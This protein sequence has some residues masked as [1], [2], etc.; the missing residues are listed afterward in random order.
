MKKFIINFI[1]LV[2]F[3]SQS[4]AAEIIDVKGL[5]FWTDT[6]GDRANPAIL[7]IMGGGGQGIMWN[8]R[9]CNGLA[10]KGYFVIRFD[11]RDTGESS[12]IDYAKNP[13]SLRE[14]A[15]DCV[16]IL[17]HYNK[18]DGHIVGVSMGGA[19]A[20]IM[21]HQFPQHIKTLTLISTSYD[22]RT[23]DDALAGRDIPTEGRLSPPTQDYVKAVTSVIDRSNEDVDHLVDAWQLVNGSK[24][25]F[26]R[27]ETR[28]LVILSESRKGNPEATMNQ[29][30]AIAA[31]N[32]AGHLDQPE[33]I[34]VPTLVIHGTEDPIFP[35]D[36]GKA[37][38]QKIQ[39]SKLHVMNLMGHTFGRS[40]E[41]RIVAAITDFIDRVAAE[42]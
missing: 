41:P 15:E 36:H 13:Y 30:K 22:F 5:K 19:I 35:L 2:A 20:Q 23:F 33:D 4:I 37:L 7:L 27:E 8:E 39:G 17:A 9:F 6:F 24:V 42:G 10:E 26:D 18:Y 31:S 3:A 29:M 12:A 14:L 11:N 25:A 28:Q 38:A 1:V 21:A 16:G 34:S 40:F 32:E